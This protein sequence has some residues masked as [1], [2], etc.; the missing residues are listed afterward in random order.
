VADILELVPDYAS[1]GRPPDIHG[2]ADLS[3]FDGLH[4]KKLLAVSV[5][6]KDE[7]SQFWCHLG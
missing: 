4:R 6:N 7:L 3:D 5:A 2:F 1:S